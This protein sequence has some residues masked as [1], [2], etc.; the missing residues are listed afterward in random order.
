MKKSPIYFGKK[1][2]IIIEGKMLTLNTKTISP[3]C[4]VT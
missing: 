3:I 4:I 2:K 1:E